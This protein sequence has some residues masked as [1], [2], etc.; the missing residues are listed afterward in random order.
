[1]KTIFLFIA[2]IT[3]TILFSQQVQLADGKFQTFITNGNNEESNIEF[4]ISNDVLEKIKLSQDFKNISEDKNLIQKNIEKR[5]V[6]DPMTIFLL[7]KVSAAGFATKYKLKNKTSFKVTENSKGKI[8]YSE[9]GLTVSFPFEA[10]NDLGAEM[11]A[12][13]ITNDKSTSILK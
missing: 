6:S 10:Q 5:N 4:S 13:S 8:Y 11:K 2:I 1:M 12:T 9:N 3:S 7:T